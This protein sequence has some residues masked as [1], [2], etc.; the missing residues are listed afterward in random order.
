MREFIQATNLVNAKFA[1]NPF[2]YHQPSKTMREF[3][4]AKNHMNARFAS[5]PSHDH[6]P[7]KNMREFIIYKCESCDKRFGQKCDLEK[8][9]NE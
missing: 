4:Q 3:I 2:Q 9:V 5:K 6:Q 7:T 1:K 8:H